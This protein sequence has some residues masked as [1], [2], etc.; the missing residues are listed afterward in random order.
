[1]AQR[2]KTKVGRPPVFDRAMTP[3]QRLRRWQARRRFE[4][5]PWGDPDLID[6]VLA[7]EWGFARVLLLDLAARTT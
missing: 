3:A 1:M 4:R 6:E 2:N 7:W 5:F